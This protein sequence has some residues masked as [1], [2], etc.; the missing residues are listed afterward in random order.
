MNKVQWIGCLLT[1]EVAGWIQE[2]QSEGDVVGHQ[3]DQPIAGN[4]NRHNVFGNS[5]LHLL[6]CENWN[7]IMPRHCYVSTARGHAW[8]DS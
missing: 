4:S 1:K 2:E 3:T 7:V 5:Q 6:L 8:K